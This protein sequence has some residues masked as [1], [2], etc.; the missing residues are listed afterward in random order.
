M[1]LGFSVVSEKT[2]KGEPNSHLRLRDFEAPMCGALY[3]TGYTDELA[4][5]FEPDKEVL[6]YRDQHELLDKVRYYLAHPDEAEKVRRAGH[7]RAMRDH[8]Y[9]CRFQKLFREIGLED[10]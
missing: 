2:G 7:A 3:A 5:Y 9:H 10:H 4:D 6:V 1:S 8:T